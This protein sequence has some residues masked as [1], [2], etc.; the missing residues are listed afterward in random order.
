MRRHSF[1]KYIAVIA[2]FLIGLLANVAARTFLLPRILPASLQPATGLL[3]LLIQIIGI[4]NMYLLYTRQQLTVV[5]K[6]RLMTNTI[7][8]AG[9]SCQIYDM[10]MLRHQLIFYLTLLNIAMMATAWTRQRRQSSTRR[11]LSIPMAVRAV[12]LAHQLAPI[13]LRIILGKRF[14]RRVA[15]LLVGTT[16]VWR[17]IQQSNW[18]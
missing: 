13:S 2:A 10:T 1:I 12:T 15:S 5:I 11:V 14:W 9:R 17:S 16:V 4:H 3:A 6:L 18:G 7:V 8:T